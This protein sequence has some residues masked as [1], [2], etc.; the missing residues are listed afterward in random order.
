MKY[1]PR[2]LRAQLTAAVALLVMMVVA[3]AGL[4]IAL[5]IDHRERSDVDRQMSVQADKVRQDVSK[6]LHDG[7]TPEPHPTDEYGELLNGS[8]TLVRLLSD[9]QVVAERGD[10][11]TNEIPPPI[12]EGYT[13]LVIDGQPWRSL[14]EPIDTAGTDQLQIL[15]NLESLEQRLDDNRQ[16]VALVAVLATVLAAVG[17][18]LITGVL[19]SPLYRLRTAALAIQPTATRQLPQVRHPQEVADLTATLNTMLDRLQ[20]AMTSTRRFTADAGHEMRTPLASLGMDL[21]TLTRNPDL[22]TDQRRH[23]LAAMTAEHQRLV[24][25]LDGLQAL[26]RGD[27]GALPAREAV[28]I[29]EAITSAI[30]YARRRHPRVTYAIGEMHES[31]VINGWAT[32]LRLAIDNLLDNAAVHGNPDG[33]TQISIDTTNEHVTIVVD[34]NGPGIPA[35]DREA[36]TQRFRRGPNPRV[37]GSGLGL[38]LVQQQAM[39]HEG[40]LILAD[41]RLGGLSARFTLPR[42]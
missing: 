36:M 28:D 40:T 30:Q 41:S 15:Q 19:L 25:V 18:W 31:V 8:Q 34:D 17:A 29:T 26:A 21:E 27:A 7:V 3:L 37:N 9:G 1:L 35:G 20:T 14:V 23:M 12:S 33:I 42:R 5:R 16:I 10:Q 11:P 22:P 32:G 24:A 6:L 39:L 4:V 38:A 2:S 13:T